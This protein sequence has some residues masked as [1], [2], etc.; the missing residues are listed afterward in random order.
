[1]QA[2]LAMLSLLAVSCGAAPPATRAPAPELAFE[3]FRPE[4]FERARRE[5]KLVLLS[6]Q[7]GWCHWCHVMNDTTYRDPEVQR[8]LAERFVVVRADGDARPDLAERYRRYAWPAT[9]FL[10]ASGR[11]LLALRGYRPPG[12]FVAIVREVLAAHAEGRALSPEAGDAEPPPADLEEVRAMLV[13]Q[14]DGMYD[15]RMGGWGRRQRYPF[16]A[17]VEHALFRAAVRG[18]TAWRERALFTL[19]RYAL[20]IDPVW[21][22]M[23]QYSEGGVWDRPHYEKIVAVQAGA[24]GAFAQ[25]H[26][27]S[28]ERRWLDRAEDVRRYV[29]AHL[30][31]GEGAFYVSQD[32]D[33]RDGE[34][35]VPGPEYYA[36]DDEERRALGI[37]R[38]D[39]HV[40]ASANGML[41]EALAELSIASGERAPLSEATAAAERVLETHRLPSGL[42]A[43]DAEAPGPLAHLADQGAHA[44]GAGG[45]APGERAGALARRGRGARGRDPRRAAGPRER[46]LLR[47]HGGS[48]SGLPRSPRAHRGQR[49]RRARAPRALAPRRP[50]RVPRGRP[51]LA[52]RVRAPGGAA[53]ARP[54]DGRVPPRA[55]A[56]EGEPRRALGGRPRRAAHARAPPRGARARRSHVPRGA[57]PPGREPLPP[58]PESRPCSSAPASPARFRSPMRAR[59]R[60][61]RA[62]SRSLITTRAA[63]RARSVPRRP[64]A[65]SRA[66]HRPG[67]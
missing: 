11:E 51:R 22:G 66:A 34:V 27:A 57:R 33:L 6:V 29:R 44:R 28:G 40:Y 10:D 16:A 24:I 21:G 17:P 59:S 3:D 41:I 50:R 58:T 61:P 47:A 30:T 52:P 43:H 19:E 31:S 8:L 39:R 23:Y 1:M 60:R 62:L 14:L 37:P 53:P 42:C 7:A 65:R 38:V 55:R 9:V 13:A 64:R 63:A 49:D 5:G 67:R 46:R 48:G 25:A 54:H 12:R 32:A 45:A 26:R 15:E 18:E 35:H 20:L 2:R 4:A 56:R 36:R